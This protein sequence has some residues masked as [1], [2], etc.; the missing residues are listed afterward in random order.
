MGKAPFQLLFRTRTRLVHQ[1]AQMSKHR[2]GEP[3][4]LLNIFVYFLVFPDA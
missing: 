2:L 3:G 4:R 1:A